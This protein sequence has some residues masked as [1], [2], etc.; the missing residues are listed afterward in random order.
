MLITAMIE[1]CHDNAWLLS[2][3]DLEGTIL[4]KS[5]CTALSLENE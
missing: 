4:D 2:Y 1:L 3:K 5:P